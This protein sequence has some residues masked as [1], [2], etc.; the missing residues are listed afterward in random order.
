M[1]RGFETERAQLRGYL[2][3]ALADGLDGG[4]AWS[5]VSWQLTRAQASA[6]VAGCR[7]GRDD[8]LSLARTLGVQQPDV[9]A[10]ERL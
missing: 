4:A 10:K 8:V 5:L 9:R 6:W 2:L 7:Q 3:A 1:Q